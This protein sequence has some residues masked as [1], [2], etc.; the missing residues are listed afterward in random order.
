MD[1]FFAGS[2]PRPLS[3]REREKKWSED[4]IRHLGELLT[5]DK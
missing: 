2:C 3:H 1:L 5:I 4:F